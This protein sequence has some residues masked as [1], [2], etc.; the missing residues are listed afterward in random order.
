MSLVLDGLQEIETAHKVTIAVEMT[1]YTRVVTLHPDTEIL[2]GA[3]E[4]GRQRVT[5]A[6]EGAVI[7]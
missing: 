4:T 2:I 1:V 3:E 7:G 5:F 6:H